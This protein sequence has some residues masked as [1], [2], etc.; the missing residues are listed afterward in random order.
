MV[1]DCTKVRRW[2]IV[3]PTPRPDASVDRPETRYA[4]TSDGVTLAYQRFGEGV[5]DLVY[6][7]YFIFNLDALWDFPPIADWLRALGRFSRVLIYDPRGVGLSDRDVEPGELGTRA[8]DMLAVLDAE[9]IRTAVIFGSLSHGAVGALLA[10]THPDRVRALIWWHACARERWA[11]DYPWG[12]SQE[13][14]EERLRAFEKG[15]G[16]SGLGAHMAGTQGP[17][18]QVDAA[19]QGW[20]AKMQRGSVTPSRAAGLL[21]AWTETD[22]RDLLPSISAPTLVLARPMTADE[23]IFVASLIPRAQFAVLP[24]PD[25]MPWFGDM[26]ALLEVVWAFLGVEPATPTPDRFVT[27]VLFTDIVDSTRQSA[28]VGDSRWSAICAEHHRLVRGLLARHG[29]NEMDT[30]GDGF[31]AT[32][33]SP[34]NAVR[35]ARDAI[36]A[37][38]VLDIEVRAGVHTGEVAV[39]DGKCQGIA[40]TIGSRIAGLAAASQVLVSRT[41]KDLTAGSGLTFESVGEHDLKGVPDRWLIYRLATG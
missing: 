15:W 18:G 40:V 24:G 12:Q 23:G 7:P 4:T 28:L 41:V 32:F 39:T 20:M 35:C 8:R 14:I 21:R 22:V 36:D 25:H 30:A 9:G 6:A 31:Y 26:H 33:D 34:G 1:S 27:T 17:T 3:M 29:G 38:R 19:F 16:S 11:E 10:A 13:E 37:V 2:L 5:V